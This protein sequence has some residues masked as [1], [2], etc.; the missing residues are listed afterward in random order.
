MT[1]TLTMASL[2]KRFID[3][4]NLPDPY[5]EAQKEAQKAVKQ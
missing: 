1:T 2:P 5:I 3:A 4:T